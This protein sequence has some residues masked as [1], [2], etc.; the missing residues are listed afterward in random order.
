MGSAVRASF[1]RVGPEALATVV[2]RRQGPHRTVLGRLCLEIKGGVEM[3][4]LRG[5]R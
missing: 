2:F 4:G 1:R 5:W 3:R